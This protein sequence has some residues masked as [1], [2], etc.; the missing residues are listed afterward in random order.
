MGV[1][2]KLIEITYTK[3]VYYTNISE[4]KTTLFFIGENKTKSHAEKVEDSC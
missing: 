2:M 4:N 1:I 3:W